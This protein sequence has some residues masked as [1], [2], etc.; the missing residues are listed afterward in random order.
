MKL[1]D[2]DS[3]DDDGDDDDDDDDDGDDVDLLVNRANKVSCSELAATL[4]LRETLMIDFQLSPQTIRN[5]IVNIVITVIVIITIV[6]T[7]IVI[8]TIVLSELP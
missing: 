7:A 6:I 8:I 3:D 5:R 2:D 1:F 4:H